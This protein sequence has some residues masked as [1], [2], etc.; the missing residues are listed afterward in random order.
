MPAAPDLATFYAAGTAL[1]AAVT[2]ALNTAHGST[3]AYNQADA[4]ANGPRLPVPRIDVF[5]AG[6]Q[7]VE[8][9]IAFVPNTLPVQ[10]YASAQRGN[11]SL[12][13]LTRRGDAT[14]AAALIGLVHATLAIPAQAIT[15]S[16][17]PYHELLMM[18]DPTMAYAVGEEAET[19]EHLMN[20]DSIVG[21]PPKNYPA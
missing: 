3:I 10:P 12:R 6:T 5:C 21:L 2:A 14:N 1:A 15:S 19:D 20:M 9:A 16:N 8:G 17:L 7:P 11:L 4:T 13:I 18:S